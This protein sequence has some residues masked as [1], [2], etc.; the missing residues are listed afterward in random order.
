MNGVSAILL[1][2]GESRRMGTLNKLALP[3]DGVPLLR[4][5]ANTL[6]ESALQE[7]VVVVGHQAQAARALLGDLPLRI[8]DNQHYRDGQM[9]SVHRGME[10]LSAP[11]DG[12][13][14]C[15]SDQPLLTA[16]DIDLLVHAFL[17]DC[18]TS[19]LVPVWQGRRGN[20]VVLAYAHRDAILGGTRNLGCRRLIE[21]NPELVT[22]LEMPDDHTVFDIDTPSDYR[23]ATQRLQSLE[24]V[25]GEARAATGH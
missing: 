22:S 18:P 2:A 5:A 15:L 12:V 6:L 14:V 20:P 13:M 23:H 9:T 19:V 21:N 4:R 1:A 16:T 8:V 25:T 10:A 7:V 3:L 11:C 17:H 24:A